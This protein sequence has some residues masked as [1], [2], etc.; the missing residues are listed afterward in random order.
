MMGPQPE[1][2]TAGGLADVIDRILDKGL[3]LDADIKV[4]VT[5]VELLDI[6]I[7]AA[8]ASFETAALY[9]LEFPSG[10]NMEAPGWKRVGERETCPVCEKRMPRE[11]LLTAGCPWCGWVRAGEKSDGHVPVQAMS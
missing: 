8:I 9:G 5:G 2:E 3:V 4:A 6:K 10:V 11:E 1:T 7:R